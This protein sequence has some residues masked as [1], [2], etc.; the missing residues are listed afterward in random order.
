MR[1]FLGDLSGFHV[2]FWQHEDVVSDTDLDFRSAE[3]SVFGFVKTAIAMRDDH[4]GQVGILGVPSGSLDVV[5]HGQF[6]LKR[7]GIREQDFPSHQHE[8]VFDR[9]MNHIAMLQE[10]FIPLAGLGNENL[11][12]GDHIFG[13]VDPLQDQACFVGSKL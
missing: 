1:Y 5:L 9:H 2:D 6:L 13:P 7:D 4:T 10:Q 8:P 3:E 11:A 12:C